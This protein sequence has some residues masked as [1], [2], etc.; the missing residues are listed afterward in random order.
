MEKYVGYE[1][2]GCSKHPQKHG[3]YIG[4]TPILEQALAVC[5]NAKKRG[6]SYFMYGIKANGEKVLF[7]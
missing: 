3:R 2:Y 7:L 6:E 5:K 4:K 1:I